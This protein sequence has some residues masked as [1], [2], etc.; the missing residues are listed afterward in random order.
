MVGL[1]D[2]A[3]GGFTS[4]ANAVSGDGSVIVGY[5]NS[6]SGVEAFI[7]DETN[8]M[9]E[10]DQVLINLGVDLTGWSL[11]EA[12]GISADGTRIVGYGNHTGFGQE[13]WIAIIPE[14]G[15]ALLLGMG[16]VAL[17]WRGRAKHS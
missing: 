9:R 5:G 11:Y 2:L 3:G 17:G 1:G 15:T 6:A 4:V 7:W 10:L 12:L 16:L 14:P 8:G 13:A